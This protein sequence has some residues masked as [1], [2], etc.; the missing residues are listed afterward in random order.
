MQAVRQ[1]T[2]ILPCACSESTAISIQE[3]ADDL[4]HRLRTVWRDVEVLNPKNTNSKLTTYQYLFAVP[5]D[6]NVRAPLRLP[7][8][9]LPVSRSKMK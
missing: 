4:R 1:G 7:I 9:L 8:N 3:F 6:H 5:F 2:S